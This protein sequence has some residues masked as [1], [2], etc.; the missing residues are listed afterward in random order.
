MYLKDISSLSPVYI[1]IHSQLARDSRVDFSLATCLG[2]YD[3][4]KYK[5]PGR[6]ELFAGTK[7][8]ALW[9][10]GSA[11]VDMLSK[12]GYAPMRAKEW[13][14]RN[15]NRGEFLFKKR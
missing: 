4:Y 10:T 15:G 9:I 1:Y 12:L 3:F 11:L 2:N 8:Y 5:E 14:E 13:E 6:S 7:D